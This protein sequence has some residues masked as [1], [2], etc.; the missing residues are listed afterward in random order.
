MTKNLL[1]PFFCARV[2]T[3]RGIYFL[4]V[5]NVDYSKAQQK[6]FKVVLFNTLTSWC[7]FIITYHGDI[8][9]HYN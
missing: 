4:A 6:D 5:N 3:T 1:I 9:Y 8:V 2:G 7:V